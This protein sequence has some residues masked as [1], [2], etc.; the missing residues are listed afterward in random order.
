MPPPRE[1]VNPQG[2]R[3]RQESMPGGWLWLVILVLLFLILYFTLLNPSVANIDYTDFLRLAE[4]GKFERVVLRGTAKAVGELK[5]KEI[6]SLDESIRN[7][8][9]GGNKVETSISDKTIAELHKKLTEIS[10]QQRKAGKEPLKIREEQEPGGW[11]GP[12][13]MMI[14]P[15]VILL[16]IFFFFL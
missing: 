10:E 13:L 5:E 2:R 3:R 12:L 16:A 6:P 15:A 7:Q 1:P 8:I 4:Q 9:R 11:V 14:L